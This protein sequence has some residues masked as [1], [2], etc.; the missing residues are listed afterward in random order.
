MHDTK[1]GVDVYKPPA[2]TKWQNKQFQVP[3]F[4]AQV[5][6]GVKGGVYSC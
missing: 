3:V 1:G 2:R 4:A 5:Y 6:R